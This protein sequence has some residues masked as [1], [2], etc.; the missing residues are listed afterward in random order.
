[1]TKYGADAVYAHEG[2]YH[3]LL[4]FMGTLANIW[5]AVYVA[6]KIWKAFEV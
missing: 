4:N 2:P 3:L 6:Y 1:M 5:Y